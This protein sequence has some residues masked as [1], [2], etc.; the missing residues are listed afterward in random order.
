MI[1]EVYHLHHVGPLRGVG[2]QLGQVI[3]G[4]MQKLLVE[5]TVLS[6][7]VH[8]HVEYVEFH[9]IVEEMGAEGYVGDE[10]FMHGGKLAN[11]RYSVDLSERYRYT[12]RGGGGPPPARPDEHYALFALINLREF[13]HQTG[14][15]IPV[16]CRQ[17]T[18]VGRYHEYEPV[19]GV[20]H[21]LADNGA[22]RLQNDPRG[23]RN[24]ADGDF[25]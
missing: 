2:Y 17:R 6:I 10:S 25:A 20:D 24:A 18:I 9:E 14:D 12:E 3:W 5:N 7:R 11:D 22:M 8:G 19:D 16:G 21:A 23:P 1:N 4:F 15:C 13:S